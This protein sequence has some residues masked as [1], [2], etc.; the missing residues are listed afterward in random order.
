MAVGGTGKRAVVVANFDDGAP[1]RAAVELDGRIGRL[2]AV[3]PEAPEPQP[4]D[5]K[6][7][8]PARSAVVALEM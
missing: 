4:C 1:L 8:V 2:A 7:V 3:T 6:V 5:G